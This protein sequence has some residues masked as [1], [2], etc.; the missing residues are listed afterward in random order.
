MER[1]K[2]FGRENI[3]IINIEASLNINEGLDVACFAENVKFTCVWQQP[4]NIKFINQ[5]MNQINIFHDN[6]YGDCTPS[7]IT[8]LLSA[9]FPSS[10]TLGLTEDA[11]ENITSTFVA[12]TP[13]STIKSDSDQATKFI[14]RKTNEILLSA[15]KNTSP[16]V[17]TSRN[18]NL[19]TKK[20]LHLS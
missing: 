18:R 10:D 7:N 13:I 9:S 20:K 17:Y 4:D 5:I 1:E 2:A 11:G 15:F 14:K 8:A 19:Y 12:S 6:D 16:I 3:S